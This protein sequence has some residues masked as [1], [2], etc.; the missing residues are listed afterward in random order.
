ML[1]RL[2][3]FFFFWVLYCNID[4]DID[5]FIFVVPTNEFIAGVVGTDVTIDDLRR[6]DG[7]QSKARLEPTTRTT[8]T[9]VCYMLE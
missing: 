4:I 7:F 8:T 1:F 9:I 3:V 5:L 6:F 2:F